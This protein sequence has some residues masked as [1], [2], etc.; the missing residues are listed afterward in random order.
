MSEFVIRETGK[1]LPKG[2][3]IRYRLKLADGEPRTRSDL[4]LT[5]TEGAS[6]EEKCVLPDAAYT[7]D[8]AVRLFSL[9]VQHTVTPCT[10]MTVYD[11]LQE[12]SVPQVRM[13]E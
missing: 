13:P 6:E 7:Y 12:K 11:N 10:A 9:F 8:D 5:V 4:E 1:D 3:K 2:K